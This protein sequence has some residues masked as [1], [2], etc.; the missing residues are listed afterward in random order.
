MVLD[1]FFRDMG[2]RRGYVILAVN[3]KKVNTATDVREFTGNEKTLT[4]IEGYQSNGTY[5]SYS[6]RR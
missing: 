3:G 1:G 4:S 6:F 2:I 5:F